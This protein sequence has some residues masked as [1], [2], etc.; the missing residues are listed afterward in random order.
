MHGRAVP[1]ARDLLDRMAWL[2]SNGQSFDDEDDAVGLIKTVKLVRR[3]KDSVIHCDIELVSHSGA[4]EGYLVNQRQGRSGEEWR[5]S[6]ST[7]QPVDLATA[8]RLF[9]QARESKLAQGFVDP[10]AAAAPPPVAPPPV[11]DTAA[12][13]APGVADRTLLQRLEHG[14]WK[15]LSLERRKRTIWRIGE[16]RL[17]AAVPSLV[18]LIE[19]GDAMQDYCIAFAIGRC[20]DRGAMPAMHELHRRASDSA[21]RR[22]ALQ[23]WLMLATE[24]ERHAHATQLFSA[25]PEALRS[26]WTSQDSA[27]LLARASQGGGWPGLDGGAWLEQLYQVAQDSSQAPLARPLLLDALRHIPLRGA[28]FAAARHLYKMAE[29]RAD[30]EVFAVLQLRFERTPNNGGE[31]VRIASGYRPEAYGPRTRNY[32]LLRGGRTLRRLGAD[33]SPDFVPMALAML[34]LYDDRDAVTPYRHGARTVDRYGH[35]PM[36]NHLLR[37]NAGLHHSSS[38]L[39]WYTLAPVP[40]T[41]QERHEAFPEL[42]DRHPEALLWL[43]LNSCSEGVHVFAA[44]AL[45][46]NP[47]WCADLPAETLRALLRSPY[48]A[49]ALF[50]FDV[51]RRRFEPNRPDAAWLLLFIAS[52]LPE[53]V[54]YV[55]D[56]TGRA[57]DIYAAEAELVAAMLV[58]P[59]QALRRQAWLLCQAAATQPGQAE[60]IVMKVLDWLDDCADADTA[61]ERLAQVSPDLLRA[62]ELPL[63]EAAAQASTP[64]L[65]QLLGHRIAAVRVLAGHWLLLHE[66]PPSALPPTIL[67]ALLRDSDAEVRAIGVRLFGALPDHLLAQQIDLVASFACAPD[68]VVR[69]AVAPI[70]ARLGAASPAFGAALL[71]ALLDGLFRAETGAGLHADLLA[72]VTGP[73]GQLPE[74]DDAQLLRRL[75]AARSKGAQ[76]LGAA[77]LA[78][79]DP[80]AFT[81]ADWAAFGCNPQASVRQ[82]A[83]AALRAAPERACADLEAALRLFDSKFDDTRDF[84]IDYFSSVCAGADWTP[85]LLV[86]LCDHPEPAAQRFGRTMISTHFDVAD[87]AD[88][89]LK[90]S[91]HPSPNM[92]LF[93][94]GWLERASSGDLAALQRL[95][96][97]FLAV[98]SQVQRGRV[99]RLRVQAFLREQAMLSADIGA[100]VAALFARQVVTVAIGDKAHYIDALRAIQARYPQLPAVLTIQP[101]PVLAARMQP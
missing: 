74:L 83:Y 20:G 46:D 9:A 24:D 54:D 71:P 49:T 17:R 70:V 2:E 29:M 28:T 1:H 47:A 94:S 66:Q 35:W 53:A 10:T 25:W 30:A 87:V 101:P 59:A 96:P 89:M 45:A 3:Q 81:V 64:R 99:T 37:A 57:L 36:F 39:T 77:L 67:A 92:Q 97:Y 61:G 44:R 4:D 56:W 15:A 50:A 6:T 22:I 68:D 72:W 86:S 33:A 5:E 48:R 95:E 13:D 12:H 43:L 60:A 19:R 14:S 82:W 23:A 78:R 85:L 55:L 79:F 16:R 76:L 58:A 98:L 90:L 8:E 27:G 26:A 63:R 34:A 11:A 52:D 91:Q 80:A 73:L 100:F 62:L 31:Y 18:D 41:A 40:D 88:V 75:L 69:R 65:L 84:A 32:L 51:A 7:P 42:W 93:V 21:V 38:S